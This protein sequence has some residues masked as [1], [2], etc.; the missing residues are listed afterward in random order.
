VEL[1]TEPPGSSQPV[2]YLDLVDPWSYL[3]AERVMT[4]LTA[5]PEWEPV[6]GAALGLAPD[7]AVD[8]SEL[9]TR[10]ERLGLQPLRWPSAWPPDGR[11]MALAATYA[12]RGGRAVCFAQAAMRQTFAG[13]RDPDE[14]STALLAAAA[15]EMHP[16]AVLKG[17]EL[18]GTAEALERAG[19]RATQHGVTALPAIVDGGRVWCGPDAL[20]QAGSAIGRDR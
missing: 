5:I 2:F 20:T 10:I 19:R 1:P 4:A 9:A 6:H 13:G 18:R 14:E 11:R 15:C 12:K 8:R 16:A 17:I 7:R 3:A